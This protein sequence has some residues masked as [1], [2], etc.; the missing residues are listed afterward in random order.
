MWSLQN[1]EQAAIKF[2][3]QYNPGW[4]IPV[5]IDEILELKLKIKLIVYPGMEERF[6]VNALINNKFDSIGI[7]QRI[8]NAQVERTRFTL[9][10]EIG[11]MVL[12]KDWYVKNGPASFTSFLDWHS[13]IDPQTYEYIERQAKTFAAFVL[14]PSNV[15]L[16]EWKQFVGTERSQ[17]Q[18]RLDQIPDTFP[19]FSKKFGVTTFSMLLRLE[20]AGK[21][22]ITDSQKDL[23]FRRK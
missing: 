6:G 10:E 16:P 20:R 4:E 3:E 14:M 22:A 18:L 13:T 8:F 7:D 2:L 15:L 5:P 9:A 21:L 23:I 19:E 11:H 12:H 17:Q 1:I